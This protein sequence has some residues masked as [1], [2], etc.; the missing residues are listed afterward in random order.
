VLAQQTFW[1]LIGLARPAN[2]Q[3]DIVFLAGTSARLAVV[4][5]C[6]FFGCERAKPP[7]F[8]AETAAEPN[9]LTPV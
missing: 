8:L 7:G 2:R 5:W 3:G 1:I 6:H 9:A 4:W